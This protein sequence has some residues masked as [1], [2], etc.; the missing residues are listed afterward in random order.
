MMLRSTRRAVVWLSLLAF[1]AVIHAL[2]SW[3]VGQKIN[4]LEEMQG[5]SLDV[6]IRAVLGIAN[7]RRRKCCHVSDPL[8]VH[9]GAKPIQR[10]HR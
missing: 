9:H 10:L 6:I 7:G 5:I 1:S 3:R 2:V 4:L 8:R